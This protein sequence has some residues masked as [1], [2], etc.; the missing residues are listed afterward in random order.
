MLT[1]LKEVRESSL[2]NIAGSCPNS[3]AFLRLVNNATRRLMRRGDWVGTIVPIQVC[4]RAGCV[5]WPRY[6]GSVRRINVCGTPIPI[7]NQWYEFL[8]YQSSNWGSGRNWWGNNSWGTLC[9]SPVDMRLQGKSPVFQDVQGEG[10]Y[11]RGY[12]TANI[13]LGCPVVRLQHRNRSAG[14]HRNIRTG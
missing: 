8:Q 2:R 12:A 3:T 7:R 10:R 14:E 1:T 6:V 5:V 9:G 4:V 13:D 11:I